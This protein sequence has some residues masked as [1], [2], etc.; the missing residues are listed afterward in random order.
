MKLIALLLVALFS[1]LPPSTA[2]EPVEP[3]APA[4]PPDLFAGPS[5]VRPLKIA[6]YEGPGSGA[7][8]VTHVTTVRVSCRARP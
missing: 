7:A 5:K 1:A 2:A 3:E 6:L 4:N 8:G